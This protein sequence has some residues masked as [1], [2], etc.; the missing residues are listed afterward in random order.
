[1]E[2]AHPCILL[3]KNSGYTT[4]K[5][6][7]CQSF[8]DRLIIII[9]EMKPISENQSNKATC[10]TKLPATTGEFVPEFH[11]NGAAAAET[12]GCCTVAH[13]GCKAALGRDE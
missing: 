2:M 13:I 5:P 3:Q 4:V 6:F 11:I 7:P 8:L 1:M 10:T 12:A 9:D